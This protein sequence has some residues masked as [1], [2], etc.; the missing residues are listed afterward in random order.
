MEISISPN[1]HAKAVMCHHAGE[2]CDGQRWMTHPDTGNILNRRIISWMQLKQD[3]TL[4]LHGTAEENLIKPQRNSR[5][6]PISE[7]FHRYDTE[8]GSRVMLQIKMMTVITVL[9]LVDSCMFGSTRYRSRSRRGW[10]TPEPIIGWQTGSSYSRWS[11][12]ALMEQCQ[13]SFQKVYK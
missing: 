2:S 11:P 13:V 1:T 8:M 5:R 7:A 4:G 10:E 3:S 6:R 12:T 9:L